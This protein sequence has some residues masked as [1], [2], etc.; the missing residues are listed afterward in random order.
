[1]YLTSVTFLILFLS[2][3]L[4]KKKGGVYTYIHLVTDVFQQQEGK[5]PD[6]AMTHTEHSR[7]SKEHHRQPV[8]RE[9]KK[10]QNKWKKWQQK[11]PATKICQKSPSMRQKKPPE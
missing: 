8:L 5:A 6:S 1:M 2:I 11:M 10:R 4:F 9:Q 7:R 3:F